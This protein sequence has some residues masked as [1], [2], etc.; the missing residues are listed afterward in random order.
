MFPAP[1]DPIIRQVVTVPGV[2]ATVSSTPSSATS[3]NVLGANL[4]RKGVAIYNDSTQVM[5]LKF[6]DT[7]STTSYTVQI[8]ASG[9]YEVPFWYAGKLDAIWAAANGNARVTEVL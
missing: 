2:G 8:P 7:A 9:Y 6:G 4:E 5:Y 1:K 3:V